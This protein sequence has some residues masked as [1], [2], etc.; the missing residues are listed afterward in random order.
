ME[1]DTRGIAGLAYASSQRA[2]EDEWAKWTRKAHPLLQLQLWICDIIAIM[3]STPDSRCVGREI[4]RKEI[5]VEP[6]R[7]RFPLAS[8]VR[9]QTPATERSFEHPVNQITRHM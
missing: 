6:L 8:P 4:C 5:S 2:R 1:A 9:I 7:L 3:G